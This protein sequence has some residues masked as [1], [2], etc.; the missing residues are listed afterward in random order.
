MRKCKHSFET[1]PFVVAAL[2]YRPRRRT[3]CAGH[4]I[5]CRQNV[6]RRVAYIDIGHYNRALLLV[7]IHC[8]DN[9]SFGPIKVKL[10]LQDQPFRS[11]RIPYRHV[12]ARGVRVT[13][14][15]VVIT[16]L[17]ATLVTLRARRAGFRIMGFLLEL[18]F[19]LR[20][21]EGAKGVAIPPRAPPLHPANA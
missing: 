5:V 7:R 9:P 11:G 12:V 6:S 13:R 20:C 15:Y 10:F 2:Q 21:C 17:G 3:E 8:N 4:A 14:L 19:R 1:N 18:A 16:H